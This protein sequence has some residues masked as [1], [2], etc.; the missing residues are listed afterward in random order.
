MHPR[1][2]FLVRD[3]VDF[4]DKS[5]IAE[6]FLKAKIVRGCCEL[7]YKGIQLGANRSKHRNA[8]PPENP[9]Y[10]GFLR[11]HLTA[12]IGLVEGNST[13]GI[14]LTSKSVQLS[15][16]ARSKFLQGWGIAQEKLKEYGR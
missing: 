7:E 10:F 9:R 14:K 13:A 1:E 11:D 3:A 12:I 16:D 8:L 2:E 6:Y 15:V 4:L 5:G